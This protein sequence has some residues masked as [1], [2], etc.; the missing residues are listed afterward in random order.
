MC[1]CTVVGV[2]HPAILESRIYL[3]LVTSFIDVDVSRPANAA[4][5]RA[6]A[7]DLGEF[8]LELLVNGRAVQIEGAGV[9]DK[10]Q[11]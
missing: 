5:G 6:T 4:I 3:L 10:V 7:T 2:L 1:D 8:E 11:Q 9:G